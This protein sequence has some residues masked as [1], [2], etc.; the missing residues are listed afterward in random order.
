MQ[1]EVVDKNLA[2]IPSVEWC[3]E[4]YYYYYKTNPEEVMNTA[5]KNK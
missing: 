4:D 1:D 3:Q 2:N 5:R